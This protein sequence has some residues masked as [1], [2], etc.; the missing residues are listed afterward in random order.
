MNKIS[1]RLQSLRTPDPFFNISYVVMMFMMATLPITIFFMWPVAIILMLLWICQWNW[2]EKWENF[3]AND[4]IPYG[5]FLLGVFL[6]PVFGF[7]NSTNMAIAWRSFECHL[8][9]L[10]APLIFLTTSSKL[11]SRNHI[12]ILLILFSASEIA[13]LLFFLIRGIY[14]TVKTGDSSF[15]YNDYYCHDYHHAYVALYATFV[16]TLIFHYLTENSHRISTQRKVLLYLAAIFLA[17]SVFCVYSR[18][19]ILTFLF[20]HLVLSGYA[21]YRK[22]SRWKY[23]VGIIFL[24]FTMFTILIATAPRN[25]FTE[26]YLSFHHKKSEEKQTDARLIIW[27]AAWDGAI[28]NL[29]W[30]VGTGDGNDVVMEKYHENGHWKSRNHPYNAHNQFLFA[31]LTNGIPGLVIIL[32]FFYAPLGLS[33]KYRDVLM[34]SLFLLMTCNC[35]VECMFDRRAGVDFFA[36]MIPLFILRIHSYSYQNNSLPS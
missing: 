15:L 3:K 17:I 16:Y 21:I 6:I 34:L 33:V 28:E 27:Q 29:P 7:V 5:L 4:G 8:W 26:S 12:K 18:A 2:R 36:I 14:N 30:G 1:S 19:G 23:V 9:F 11:W 24:I 31:L 35:L 32:L 25:R 20:L 10:F 13:I 22:P